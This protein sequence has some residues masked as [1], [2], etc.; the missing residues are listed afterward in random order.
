[1]NNTQKTILKQNETIEKTHYIERECEI[2]NASFTPFFF[3][4]NGATGEEATRFQIVLA[5]KMNFFNFWTRKYS[6]FFSDF[7]IHL[8]NYWHFVVYVFSWALACSV[9]CFNDVFA[10]FAVDFFRC[11]LLQCYKI[12]RLY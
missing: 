7:A 9:H 8:V 6:M 3:Q 1:M 4:N 11:F 10:S 2:E 12:P 5:E